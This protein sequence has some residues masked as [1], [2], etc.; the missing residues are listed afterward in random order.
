MIKALPAFWRT[1]V[2]AAVMLVLLAAVI[3]VIRRPVPG[4]LDG[5][6]AVF[7]D[8]NGLRPGDDVRMYGMAVGKVDALRLNGTQAEVR[9]TVQHAHPIYAGAKLVIRYQTLAG[10]RYIDVRQPD[11]TAEMLTPG[12]V[13]GTDH[14]VPAFDITGLFNGLQPVLAQASPEAVNRFAENMLA[15]L[16]GD[17]AGI[18]SALDAVEQLAGYVTDRQTVLSI[19]I[20]NLR[21]MS[22][23]L[24]DRS[25][26]LV[27]VI[28][29][30]VDVFATLEQQLYG[31]ADYARTIPSLLEPLDRL[32]ARL[33]LTPVTNPEFDRLLRAALP[34]PE[35][36]RDV[37]ARLPA[38]LQTLDAFGAAAPGLAAACGK[39]A[40]ALPAPLHMLVAG[41]GITIC[42]G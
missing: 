7:T 10:Q 16:E 8:A 23:V 15:L 19:L 4:S 17:G 25:P 3:Q 32:A 18:G 9:F 31:V 13:F 41:Q 38:L 20:H 14:T 40:V 35:A 29:G 5:F 27:T 21:E 11:R 6:T 39:G 12:T 37:L 1:T 28:S 26:H 22:D 30:L 42:A 2:F 34:D 33:G 24:A 36:A